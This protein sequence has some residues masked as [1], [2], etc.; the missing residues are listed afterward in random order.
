MR[1]GWR[2]RGK[3]WRGPCPITGEGKDTCWALPADYIAD[4]VLIGC[5]RCL[6]WGREARDAHLEALAPG[7][8]TSPEAPLPA[9]PR[10][11][12]PPFRPSGWIAPIWRAGRNVKGSPG[13]R[14]LRLGRRCWKQGPL[15]PSVRWLEATDGAYGR[16][17]PVPPPGAAGVVLYAYRGVRDREI[18]ALQM[19][20][21]DTHGERLLWPAQNAKRVSLAGSLFDYGRQRFEV[22][23]RGTGAPLLLVE[24]PTS[25]LAALWHL[26]VLQEGWSVIGTAGWAGFA[27]GALGDA[28]RI[29][30]FPDG[31][32]PSRRAAEELG[33]MAR[34]SG[35]GVHIE[36]VPDGHD[37]L[38]LWLAEQAGGPVATAPPAGTETPG[39]ACDA[40]A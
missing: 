34:E 7:G 13:D 6:P 33:T 29:W 5:H 25:A 1:N 2:R 27:M 4:G 37:L 18:G 16:I 3:E 19:E 35:R 36:Q 40:G 14:Y 24:G 39:R 38:D 30:I 23:W 22:Q 21:V 17:R 8:E 31:D 32:E 26:P 11:P 10:R 12:R 28:H 20:A 15:P 9:R